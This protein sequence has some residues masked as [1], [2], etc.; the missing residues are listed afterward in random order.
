AAGGEDEQVDAVGQDHDP[1]Q[2]LDDRPFEQ[3][4]DAGRAED[5]GEQQECEVG[6]H[7]VP[8]GRDAGPRTDPSF[9]AAWRIAARRASRSERAAVSSTP[10]TCR[11]AA[12]VGLVVASTYTARSSAMS[13]SS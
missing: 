4:V 5:P 8:P 11:N 10:G 6:G 9:S 3:Q 2:D 13:S 1:Q 7:D 12:V